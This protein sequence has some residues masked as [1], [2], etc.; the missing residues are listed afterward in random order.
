M[1]AV[2]R[3]TGRPAEPLRNNRDFLLLWIGAGCTALGLRIG[4]ITYPLLVLWQSGSP[5]AAGWV[6]FAALAPNLVVQ[7]PA[8]VL[9][10]RYDRR[11]L[12]LACDAGCALS[13]ASV[14]AALVTGAA[15]W[16]FLMIVAFAQGSLGVV[17]Q[18]AERSA[19]R[20][21]VVAGHLSQ[22]LS[23]NEAR[24]RAAALLGQPLGTG[25][26]ALERTLPFVFSTLFH[27][28]SFAMLLMLRKRLQ[29]DSERTREGIRAEISAGAVW[30][31]RHGFLRDVMLLIAISN[32]LFQGLNLALMVI[33]AEGGRSAA[34]VGPIAALSGVGGLVGALT[35]GAWTSR[36]TLRALIVGGLSVWAVL[37]APIAVTGDPVPLG[38]L[39]CVSGYIGGLINVTG[40]LYMVRATPDELMGRVGGFVTLIALGPVGLGSLAAGQ[41]LDLFGSAWTVAGMSVIMAVLGGAAALS[42]AIRA[43]NRRIDEVVGAPEPP[44]GPSV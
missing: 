1:A 30:V 35:C 18:L 42:P 21:V 29:A 26:Y 6:G 41:A 4:V 22:A 7:L 24:S 10:D 5:S 19:V 9:V 17:Y 38:A 23:R 12:M 33:L 28:V 31:W 40:A 8:G 2:E 27:M 44:G 13:T 34:M 37:I 20:H 25:L 32:M 3:P 16:T 36:L 15:S 14:A 39:F 11:R 43:A